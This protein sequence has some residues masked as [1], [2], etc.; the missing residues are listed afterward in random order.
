MLNRRTLAVVVM[1][2]AA[3]AIGSALFAQMTGTAAVL[4]VVVVQTADPAAYA[5]AIAEGQEMLTGL[6]SEATIRVWQ[7]RFAGQDA[8][9][10]VSSIEWPSMSAMAADDELMA[11]S[12]GMRAWLAGLSELRTIVSDSLY[13]EATQ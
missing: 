10:V 4:R 12:A 9:A 8:G 11:G 1:I 2:V 3:S 6:G 13:Q 5:A 7:A